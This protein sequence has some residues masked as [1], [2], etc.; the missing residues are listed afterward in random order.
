MK[1]AISISI[2][3]SSRDKEAVVNLLGEEVHISRVGTDGDMQAA[4]QMYRD[5]D[6]KVDTFGLGGTDLGLFV[7]NKWYQLLNLTNLTSFLKR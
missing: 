1:K 7:D 6:G 4:R 2:G 5:L 3:S